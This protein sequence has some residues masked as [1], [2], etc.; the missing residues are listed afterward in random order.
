MLNFWRAIFYSD[1]LAPV[2]NAVAAAL[3]VTPQVCKEY[4]TSGIMMYGLQFT[5]LVVAVI[6]A[7]VLIWLFG[8]LNPGNLPKYNP[9]RMDMKSGAPGW[10]PVRRT[11]TR[12]GFSPASSPTGARRGRASLN[13]LGDTSRASGRIT[14]TGCCGGRASPARRSTPPC[15]KAT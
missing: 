13:G 5:V 1:L 2:F 7:I 4:C 12:C 3:G 10:P 9:D 11:K 14:P 6:A 15:S 8:L